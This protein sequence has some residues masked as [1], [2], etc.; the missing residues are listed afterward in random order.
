MDNIKDLQRR[1]LPK[2]IDDL[3][4]TKDASIGLIVNNEVWFDRY[5]NKY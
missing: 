3:F 2:F 4:D 5:E 1:E